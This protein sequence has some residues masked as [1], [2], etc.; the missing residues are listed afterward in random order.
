VTVNDND[1][2]FNEELEKEIQTGLH[3]TLDESREQDFTVKVHREEY[4]VK[5]RFYD[6]EKALETV[7]DLRRD[8]M[9]V[10]EDNLDGKNIS[11]EDEDE[12]ID[13]DKLVDAG[14]TFDPPIAQAAVVKQGEAPAI[15]VK[16][17][18]EPETESTADGDDLEKTFLVKRSREDAAE[19]KAPETKQE[20][21]LSDQE[22]E[23]APADE[24]AADEGE[25]Q[26]MAFKAKSRY[27]P[28]AKN[29]KQVKEKKSK[30]YLVVVLVL[31]A[32]LSAA[33]W[34]LKSPPENQ[35]VESV[36]PVEKKV[37]S[38]ARPV[39]KAP[40]PMP[41]QDAPVEAKSSPAEP[42]NS[43]SSVPQESKNI[44]VPVDST[45]RPFTV[46]VASY[47]ETA[48]AMTFIAQLRS[49]GHTAYSGL[50]SIPGKGDWYRVYADTLKTREDA[51]AL[52]DKIKGATGE[53]AILVKAPWSVQ[54][55][56]AIK[57]SD[58]V[59]KMTDRKSVV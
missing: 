51:V 57:D 38:P 48:Q 58:A 14:L 45:P 32:C 46:H 33:F 29:L 27:A 35:P 13:W 9:N 54:V 47:K 8:K 56:S 20:E 19:E 10:V 49:I 21:T 6:K 12:R 42:V 39:E 17:D 30:G 28:P 1:N 22:P 18:E 43:S 41:V 40:E 36:F 59:K 2:R 26:S 7:E 15:I 5:R 53:D 3:N 25:E 31:A 50:V 4:V 24:E 23:A 55:G 37:I 44:I 11:I 52:A 16:Q 34:F